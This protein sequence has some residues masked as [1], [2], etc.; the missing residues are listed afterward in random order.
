LS[1]PHPGSIWGFY[2]ERI[3]SPEQPRAPRLLWRTA[4][5]DQQRYI[6]LADGATRYAVNLARESIPA[7]HARTRRIAAQL[8]VQGFKPEL[9]AQSLGCISAHITRVLGIQVFPTQLM[10][11]AA[12]LDQQMAEMATGEGKTLAAGM[13]AAVGG[14][15][16]TPVHVLTANEYLASRDAQSLAPLF[17][18][19]Q[20][21]FG[22]ARE[23]DDPA[24]RQRAYEADIVYATART[25]AFDYLRDRIERASSR[26]DLALRV[27][28]SSKTLLLR[29]LCMVIIDEADSIL[30]DEAKMPLIISQTVQDPAERSRSWQALDMA[31]RLQPQDYQIEPQSR[32]ISLT[33]M[34]RKNV[35]ALGSEYGAIWSNR[36]HREE[37][38][39]QALTALRCLH[40][41]H[42]YLIQDNEIVII[43]A[44]TG[45]SAPGRVWSRGLH[46]VVALKE[47]LEPPAASRTQAQ[48]T[49]PRLFSRYHHLCGLSGTLSEVAGELRRS[50]EIATVTIPLFRPNR[51]RH[52]P[53][54]VLRSRV[55][56]FTAAAVRARQVLA[57]G[58]PLLM[59]VDSVLDSR[60]LVS[61]LQKQSIP[62]AVLNAQTAADEAEVV[63]CAG[64]IVQATVATQMAGR[65][66]DIE[67]SPAVRA[68]GG[69]HVLNLQHNRSRRLDRQI[70]GRAGRQG[71]PGTYEH[72]VCLET[73]LLNA[74]WLAT[75]FER[76]APPVLR[77]GPMAYRIVRRAQRS[78][79]R[80]DAALRKATSRQDRDWS[81]SL[82][83]TTMTE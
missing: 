18:A 45:R 43:D 75:H 21:S 78:A 36:L 80:E 52:M 73:P 39:E 5:N 71:Q 38:I 54:R 46:S 62:H 9:I 16:G 13:A 81:Q 77:A 2:P 10:C 56:L 41:D 61:I 68:A 19:L 32:Q 47:G 34:G 15:V 22:V 83:F 76:L 31:R 26:S 58:R 57:R 63:A 17:G 60:L 24:D 79:E 11:A 53:A 14:L 6:E 48:I 55:A 12:L 8:T 51:R 35:E 20:L 72:W 66:T 65:G 49:Y 70:A 64:R 4:R 82:H 40:R 50:Y 37:L 69:L 7:L 33:A 30:I 25:V 3:A 59:T 29:G 74:S 44:V 67:L 23:L 27:S 1:I 28:A 42:D